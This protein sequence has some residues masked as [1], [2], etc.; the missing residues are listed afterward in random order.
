[1]K[2]YCLLSS[3]QQFPKLTVAPGLI[4]HKSIGEGDDAFY[5]DAFR[6]SK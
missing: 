3:V 5:D 4:K 2:L 1:M 6:G